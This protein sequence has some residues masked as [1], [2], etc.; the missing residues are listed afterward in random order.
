MVKYMG[1]PDL[2][3]NWDEDTA[4]T[5]TLEEDVFVGGHLV[6]KGTSFTLYLEEDYR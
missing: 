2:N 3:E 4:H 5:F 6:T 1:E